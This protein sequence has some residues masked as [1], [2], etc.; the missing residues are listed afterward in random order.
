[1]TEYGEVGGVR[2]MRR[3]RTATTLRS[4]EVYPVKPFFGRRNTSS[5][6]G[7]LEGCSDNS[8]HWVPGNEVYEVR[9]SPNQTNTVDKENDK[10]QKGSPMG[11]RTR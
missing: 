11:P 7:L 1:M 9:I 3:Q 10:T 8:K 4:S 6:K 5:N 2:D